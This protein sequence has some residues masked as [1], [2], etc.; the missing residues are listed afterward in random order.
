LFVYFR[1]IFFGDRVAS[2]ATDQ[3]VCGL[4]LLVGYRTM[5]LQ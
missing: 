5:L 3:P 2:L 4:L 1:S